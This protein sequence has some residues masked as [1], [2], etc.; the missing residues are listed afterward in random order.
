MREADPPEDL[1]DICMSSG[2]NVERTTWCG[3]TVGIECGCDDENEGGYCG[4]DTCEACRKAE[5]SQ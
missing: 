1:C 2:V 5:A 3:M 4:D